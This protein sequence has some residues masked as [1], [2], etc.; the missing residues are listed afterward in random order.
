MYLAV[1]L[2]AAIMDARRSGRGQ[3]VDAAIVDGSAHMLGLLLALHGSGQMPAQ[4]GKGLLDGPHWYNTYRCADGHFISVGSLEPRFYRELCRR[5]SISEDPAF[6]DGY[7]AQH[8]PSLKA[9]F[10]E[11]FATRPRAE[12]VAL[13]EGTD[14]CFAPVLTPEEAAEHPHLRERGVY[15]HD[16]GVL[17]AAPAPRF[18]RTPV[19]DPRPIP[20]ARDTIDAV[21]ADWRRPAGVGSI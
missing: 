6:D 19:H 7:Q 18:S 8:W 3:V 13:L 16:D 2:L 12:W 5:L 4:R 17:Q 1:G 20:K 15:R 11:L 21:L 9:R 10:S 14:A